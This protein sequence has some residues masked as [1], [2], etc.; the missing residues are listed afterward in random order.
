MVLAVLYH[1]FWSGLILDGPLAG[2]FR[3]PNLVSGPAWH[4]CGVRLR[5]VLHSESLYRSVL[6]LHWMAGCQGRQNSGHPATLSCGSVATHG[7]VMVGVLGLH[8]NLVNT[9]DSFISDSFVQRFAIFPEQFAAF[10]AGVVFARGFAS[11]PLCL[12]WLKT[13]PP[14]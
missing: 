3:E 1:G 14:P 13:L 5:H 11:Q 10:A 9:I 7:R 8:R 6:A 12:A 4:T 2:T